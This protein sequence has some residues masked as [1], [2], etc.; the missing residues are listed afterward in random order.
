LPSRRRCRKLFDPLSLPCSS[1]ERIWEFPSEVNRIQDEG[2][3]RN[4][5]RIPRRMQA[6]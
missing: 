5:G 4:S 6:Q 3:G 1:K 2:K